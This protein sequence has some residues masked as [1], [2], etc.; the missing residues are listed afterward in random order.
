MFCYNPVPPRFAKVS[1]RV[2]EVR[3]QNNLA[4]DLKD[5][6]E[7]REKGIPISSSTLAD[8]FY[9]GQE[10]ESFDI[11]FETTRGVD[12]NDVWN[13]SLD[14]HQKL[15]KSKLKLTDVNPK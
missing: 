10:G 8:S 14:E 15:T 6:D 13:Y 7:L 12:M 11:A 4:F 3:T 2:D 1:V 9:D 5:M